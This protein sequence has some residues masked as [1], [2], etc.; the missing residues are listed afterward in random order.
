MIEYNAKQRLKIIFSLHGTVLPNV[1]GYVLV[2]TLWTTLVL[3][4]DLVWGLNVNFSTTAHTIV[5]VALGLLLVFR[6]NTSYDRYWEGRIR[7]SEFEATARNLAMRWDAVIPVEETALRE[8]LAELIAGLGHGLK[9]HLREGCRLEHL[10]SL[11]DAS[12]E[13]VKRYTHPIHGILVAL[14]R[15]ARIPV[16]QGWI[17]APEYSLFGQDLN[18]FLDIMKSLDRIRF[19]PIPFAYVNQLKVFMLLYLLTLP[20]ALIS[21]L[22]WLTLLA[23]IFI[24]YALVGIEEI[25]MEIEDPFG[26]DANDLPIEQFCAGVA[27]DAREILVTNRA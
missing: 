20:L 9:E 3:I 19:T 16:K 6:T 27:E 12:R 13:E 1:F 11:S 10:T 8:E 23:V 24:V 14:H 4:A 21:S 2:I 15:R 7:F 18:A 22:G 17:A 5:G 26:Q 25:G